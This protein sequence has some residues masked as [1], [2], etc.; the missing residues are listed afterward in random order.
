MT[1]DFGPCAPWPVR[2]TCDVSTES[3]TATG[4][5]VASATE[6]L[7]ALSGRRF[8]TCQVT[9]R[10][11]REDCYGTAYWS[12]Y[13][14]PWP[15]S[16]FPSM[17]G[18]GYSWGWFDSLCGS[19][20]G[21][22]SCSEISEVRL[23]APVSSIVSVKIDG[24]PMVTGGAAYRVDDNRLLVRTDGQRWPRCND[25]SKDDTQPGTWSVTA[26]Y[27]EEIPEMAQLAVGQLA[28]EILK[29]ANGQDCMLPAGITQLVREG[30]TISYPDIGDLWK[31]GRTGLYLVDAFLTTVNPSGLRH[32]A[33]TYRV[34]G[35][36]PRRVGT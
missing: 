10:P 6:V 9:L 21:T 24:T 17:G 30:V 13:G 11:C 19:C 7:W 2:W 18:W 34:D 20:S 29:S 25:L 32:R 36:G 33:K 8:G 14:A 31:K 5:A 23:P 3:P 4:I 22:C 16:V 35:R 27:G 12:S 1:A 26:L 15:A 28:C